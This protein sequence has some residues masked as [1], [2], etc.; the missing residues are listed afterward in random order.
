MK[1][2][3]LITI[4]LIAGIT[5]Q[6]NAQDTLRLFTKNRPPKEHSEKKQAYSSNEIRTI[7][8][9]GHS[10]GF[11]LG[12]QSGYSQIYGYDALHVGTR[13]AW[14]SN[15]GFAIG[16]VG[17]GFF[18]EP[19]SYAQSSSKEYNYSGGYGGLLLE[20]I[21]FPKMPVHLSFPIILGAGGIAR[22]VYY[23][24]S[25]PYET[26]DAYVEASDAFAILEPG[27]EL[28]LNIA[29][30]IRFGVGCSYRFTQGIDN[31]HFSDSPL[32]GWTSGFSLKFGKF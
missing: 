27:A 15:H 25:Y 2:T 10:N 29:R 7:T 6:L 4:L 32:D 14:I 5:V 19:Q 31:T 21:L 28:E 24:L 17:N 20:P 1:K 30:W 12:M 16:F 22:S 11:Y 3:A 18:S 26:T 23:D 13:I 9:R 8:G